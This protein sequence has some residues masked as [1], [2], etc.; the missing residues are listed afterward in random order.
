MVELPTAWKHH[1][2]AITLVCGQNDAD[3]VWTEVQDKCVQACPEPDRT[4]YAQSNPI[5][6]KYQKV[7]RFLALLTKRVNQLLHLRFIRR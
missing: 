6:S 7:N 2:Y 5:E 1:W 3:N 4:R